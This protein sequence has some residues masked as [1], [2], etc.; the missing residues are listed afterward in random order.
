M[1]VTI[2]LQGSLTINKKRSFLFL[3]EKTIPL[4]LFLFE[5]IC[6]IC[7]GIKSKNKHFGMLLGT[8]GYE[9]VQYYLTKQPP[10][11]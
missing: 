5:K 7:L 3:F 11:R 2:P 4:F 8:A 10:L 6:I 1:Y 9:A